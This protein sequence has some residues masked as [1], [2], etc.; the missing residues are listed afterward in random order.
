MDRK[1]NPMALALVLLAAA[2][3]PLL[4]EEGTGQNAQEEIKVPEFRDDS[5]RMELTT[6]FI[7]QG[8]GFNYIFLPDGKESVTNSENSRL[9]GELRFSYYFNRYKT[10]GLEATFGFTHATGNFQKPT[11]FSDPDNPIVFPIDNVN[12]NAFH[13]G[14]NAIYNFG[15]LDV[16]P[17]IT[18]GVGANDFRPADDSSFTLDGMYYDIEFSAGF[19]Y[20]IKEWFGV[21]VEVVDTLYFLPEE[22]VGGNKNNIRFRIGSVLTF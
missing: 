10:F 5:R 8:S 12:H 4:A 3:L 11:D 22:E 7:L 15:Y 9:S 6:S 18:L 13:Y 14:A 2:A 20:F 16:V 21:R 19:K 17:F 1:W